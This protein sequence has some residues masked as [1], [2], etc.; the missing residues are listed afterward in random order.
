MNQIFT[1]FYCNSLF[2]LVVQAKNYLTKR[3][4]AEL[5][6][7][8]VAVSKMIARY[9]LVES[10]GCV[11]ALIVHLLNVPTPSDLTTMSTGRRRFYLL[12]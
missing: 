5:L 12:A 7:C 1:N 2:S 8:L 11:V 3:T 6:E 4:T 9:D 10:S